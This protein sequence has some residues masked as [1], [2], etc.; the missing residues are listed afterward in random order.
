MNRKD[1]LLLYLSLPSA[2]SYFHEDVIRIQYSLFFFYMENKER[3]K[4]FY[5]F[6]SY[7]YGPS[8]LDILEDLQELQKRGLIDYRKIKFDGPIY[9]TVTFEGRI[10][11]KKLINQDASN[12]VS[13]FQIIKQ[14]ITELSYLQL[15]KLIEIQYPEY[16]GNSIIKRGVL[17]DINF[18]ISV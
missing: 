8:S 11:A 15:L 14:R 7:L 17:D 5:S 3:L 2:N 6:I 1:W 12:L 4:D 9:Y 16:T 10:K 13:G 18:G